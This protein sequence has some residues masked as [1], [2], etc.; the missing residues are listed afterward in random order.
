MPIVDMLVLDPRRMSSRTSNMRLHASRS[1]VALQRELIDAA[2]AVNEAPTLDEAFQALAE[3]GL[4]LLGCERLAV[5]SWNENLSLGVIRADTGPSLGESVPATPGSAEAI[6][7]ETAYAGP[8]QVE[9]FSSS[10]ARS[11]QETAFVVR[12][13]LVTASGIATFHALWNDPLDGAEASAATEI[14]RTL[15]RLTSIAERSFREGERVRLDSVLDGVA[16]GVVVCTPAAATP[17]A[18]ARALL[19]I[20]D[21]VAFETALMN[22]R[23]LDGRPLDAAAREVLGGTSISTGDRGRFRMR[24]TT[25]DGRE[26]VLD[27]TVSRRTGGC[28]DRLPRRHRRAR[29]RRS[30]RA[31]PLRPLQLDPDPA[32]RHRRLERRG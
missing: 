27:G 24:V 26:L 16:D 8:P 5:V 13:P 23:D 15:T 4:A 2:I 1:E 10:L 32:D 30:E 29:P 6:L 21:G 19:A 18:A 11:L 17:N 12:V 7:S 22:P 9:G 3:T 31:V 20:P 14:L 25:L 28:G